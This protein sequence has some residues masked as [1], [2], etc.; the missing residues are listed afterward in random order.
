[1][2]INE[3]FKKTPEPQLS[4]SKLDSTKRIIKIKEELRKNKKYDDF[5]IFHTTQSGNIVFK[6]NRNVPSDERGLLLLDLE[7][8]L[9]KNIDEALTVWLE[10]VG[11][12]SKL[13]NLR[14]IK[15]KAE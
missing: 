11:D 7:N 1:M 5:E 8:Q 10:P 6:I 3:A 2:F 15:F 9:K 13:R 12:K 14:G 4:W